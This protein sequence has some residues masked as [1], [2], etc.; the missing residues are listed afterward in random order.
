[1]SDCILGFGRFFNYC[2]DIVCNE[3]FLSREFIRHALPDDKS[4]EVIKLKREIDSFK[5]S[6]AE[7]DSEKIDTDSP[8]HLLFIIYFLY[9]FYGAL[10]G[11]GCGSGSSCPYLNLL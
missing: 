9:I 8:L 6:L 1:M 10:Y 3:I 7:K 2:F 11:C 5:V 4:T